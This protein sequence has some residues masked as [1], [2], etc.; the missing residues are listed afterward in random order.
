MRR[1]RPLLIALTLS[2]LPRSVAAPDTPRAAGPFTAA[3]AAAQQRVVKLY[4]AGA[5]RE[6]AYGSGVL[7]APDGRI[8]TAL[9]AM[10]EGR[11]LRAVLPDGRALPARILARD[12]VRQLALLKID[13]RD[14]PCFDLSDRRPVP[15]GTW[16][17]AATNAFKV[18]DGPEPVSVSVGVL[19][20]RTQLLA[21]HRTR[22]F[23]YRGPVLLTDIIVSTPGC[24]GGALL[25]ADGRLIGVIGRPV[26]D[27][28]T[29][30]W[31]NYALPVEEVA[32]F[33]AGEPFRPP[34]DANAPTPPTLAAL[35]ICLFDVGGRARPAY[36]ERVRPDSPARRAGLQPDDLILAV[37][38][39]PTPTCRDVAA[40]LGRSPYGGEPL[41]LVIKRGQA[42][43]LISLAPPEPQ[44]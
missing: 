12:E 44:P 29:N 16:V 8:V 38:D 37:G 42:V 28:R 6:K 34:A 24:A 40:A 41:V 13:A 17:V 33:V 26:I 21:R 27:Q 25:D 9:S 43:R 11:T 22:D 32:R 35:G 15:P 1:L 19:A 7:V 31:L 39:E 30:T 4:G 5:G 36:V 20:G 23:P 2:L 14:L 3:I 10:L 18:A